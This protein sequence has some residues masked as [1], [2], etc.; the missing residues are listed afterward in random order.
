MERQ[1]EVPV[2]AYQVSGEYAIRFNDNLSASIF[3]EAGNIWSDPRLIDP[4]RL[5]RSVGFGGTVVTP[6]GPLGI[7]MAYGFDKP[8][9]GWKFHCKI[10]PAGF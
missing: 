1:S 3:A 8:D 2:W 10:N 7:D 9:P 6:F 5:Y 4:T